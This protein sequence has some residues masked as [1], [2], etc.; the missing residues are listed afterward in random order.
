[1]YSRPKTPIK[2]ALKF[3]GSTIN[4]GPKKIKKAGL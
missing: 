3:I 1:M 4:I 2:K